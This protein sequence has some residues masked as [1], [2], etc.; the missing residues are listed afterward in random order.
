MKFVISTLTAVLLIGSASVADAADGTTG[1]VN[2]V[3]ATS[4]IINLTHG[5]I[6]S[7]NWPGMT[8]DFPVDAAVDLTSLKPG[9]TVTFTVTRGGKGFYFIDSMKRN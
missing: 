3:D 4:H 5:P 1:K 6:A 8:M 9:D 2:K 7:L